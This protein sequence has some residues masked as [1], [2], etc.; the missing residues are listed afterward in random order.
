MT[1]FPMVSIP[2][3]E[4]RKVRSAAVG[5][6]YCISIALP[7]SYRDQPNKSYPVIYLLDANLYFGMV[8]EM[9][10][11]MNFRVPFCD[12]LPDALIVGI[13]YPVSGSLPDIFD[14]FI[15]LRT[16]D[17]LPAVDEDAEKAMRELFP[18]LDRVESGGGGHFLQFIHQ[19]LI[20]M[21]DAAYRTNPTDRTLMG[22]SWGG[23][24]VLY[25]LFQLP[26]LFQR[27]VV[28]SPDIPFS[29]GFIRHNEREYAARH[30]SLP[31]QLYFAF[32]E[33][34]LNDYNVPHIE[35]FV[36]AIKQQNYSGFQFMYQIIAHCK[37]CGVV[38]PAFQ[39]GL[40][41]VF[42]KTLQT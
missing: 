29:N 40:S 32:G 4:M 23:L 35:A 2:E 26:E 41:K 25:A 28:V 36:N 15:Q 31:V 8:T 3:T 6:E 27:Y 24:F 12:E 10:R 1:T 14:Q 22:H 38:A 19:E 18:R 21:I 9:V 30:E 16:R 5:Q 7:P 13:G 17:L 11:A 37:H 39:A 33:Q 20:P 34:E 42:D